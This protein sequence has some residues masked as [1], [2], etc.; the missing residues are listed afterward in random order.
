MQ[1]KASRCVSGHHEHESLEEVELDALQLGEHGC[2]QRD[3]LHAVLDLGS[4]KVVVKL[5][6]SGN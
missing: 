3:D 4:Y 6:C 5:E 1:H 2:C